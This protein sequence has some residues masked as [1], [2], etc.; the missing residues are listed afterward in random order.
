V[1]ILFFEGKFA[2]FDQVVVDEDGKIQAWI[3]LTQYESMIVLQKLLED[4][5]TTLQGV[6]MQKITM[7][8]Y[9]RSK[10]ESCIE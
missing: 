1:P 8:R 7:F 2:T 4:T 5:I 3:G 10:E 9:L 6:V